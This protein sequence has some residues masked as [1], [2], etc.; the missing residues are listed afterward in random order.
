MEKGSLHKA[1]LMFQR[2]VAQDN[3]QHEGNWHQ[4][5]MCYCEDGRDYESAD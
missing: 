1:E 2:Q 5:G 4:R 3:G